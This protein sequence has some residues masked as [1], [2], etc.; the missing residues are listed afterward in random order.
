MDNDLELL[1]EAQR[2]RRHREGLPPAYTVIRTFEGE[3]HD[4][5]IR[6]AVSHGADISGI[7]LLLWTS[8]TRTEWGDRLATRQARQALGLWV[9]S[10]RTEMWWS[11]S[12]DP[13]KAGDGLQA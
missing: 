8:H 7:V 5:S 3:E 13:V 2:E 12:I 6:H 9:A 4:V 10:S 1:A 11:W